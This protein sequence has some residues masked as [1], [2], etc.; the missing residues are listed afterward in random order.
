MSSTSTAFNPEY[1]ART[2]KLSN[3]LM[4]S[5]IILSRLNSRFLFREKYVTRLDYSVPGLRNTETQRS[6]FRVDTQS[7]E[8]NVNVDATTTDAMSIGKIA[9]MLLRF[10]LFSSGEV[11]GGRCS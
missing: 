4:A 11:H 9:G 8:L 6:E 5:L 7:M 2:S 3:G 1:V 10:S